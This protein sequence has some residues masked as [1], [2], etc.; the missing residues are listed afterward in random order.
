MNI[1]PFLNTKASSYEDSDIIKYWVS[2][3]QDEK[4]F[5]HNVMVP[6]STIPIRILGGKGSG[7]THILRY[8]SFLSQQERAKRNKDTSSLIDIINQDKYIGVY[9]VASGLQVNRF[10]GRGIEDGVWQDIFYYYINLEFIERVMKKVIII[11]QDSNIP[12]AHDIS[13]IKKCF[14]KSKTID[15][16]TCLKELYNLIYES[17]MNIDNQIANFR[18]PNKK[19][20][21]DINPLFKIEDSFY[22]IIYTLLN[23]IPELKD[24]QVLLIIDEFENFSDKQQIYFNT[25]LRQP[26]Y[27]TR[28]SFRISGRLWAIKTNKTLDDGE[29]LHEDAEVRTIYLEELL[30]RNFEYFASHLYKLRIKNLVP[31]IEADDINFDKTLMPLKQCNDSILEDIMKVHSI[32]ENK[33]LSYLLENLNKQLVLSK[34]EIKMIIENINFADNWLI[35]KANI[36]LLYKEWNKDLLQVSKKIKD[37]CTLYLNG[38]KSEKNLHINIF[39][40]HKMDLEYQLFRIYRRTLSYGGYK[41]LLYMANGNPRIFL[42]SLNKI[43]VECKFNNIDMFLTDNITCSIQD[44]ALIENSKW[45]WINFTQDIKDNRVTWAIKELCEF[46]RR[47]RGSDKPNEK[48]LRSFSY[49]RINIDPEVDKLITLAVQH[50]LLIESKADGSDKTTSE[51]QRKLRV[52]PMLTPRWELPL[53]LG[54]TIEL[55]A[56]ELEAL[57]LNKEREWKKIADERIAKLNVPFNTNDASFHTLSLF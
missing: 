42:S 24:I 6:K 26:K 38:I 48:N 46:F 55:K 47:S 18:L 28:I 23:A 37:S 15:N 12:L 57:F 3:S 50:S 9:V 51:L 53:K 54:G 4:D 13:N 14:F 35:E 10:S 5:Y 22:D 11:L 27:P 56:N 21:L 20:S 52:H 44:N 30:E 8:F 45:F 16:I 34:E 7:K 1:N 33:H 29:T 41:N 31:G 39:A 49:D 36:L 25:L 2:P 19:I 17:R 32:K 43:F 40:K